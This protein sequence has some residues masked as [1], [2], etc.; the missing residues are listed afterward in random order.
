MCH[1]TTIDAM[2]R[3]ELGEENVAGVKRPIKGEWYS[4]AREYWKVGVVCCV[5]DDQGVEKNY[6]G[7]LGGLNHINGIDLLDSKKH[8]EKLIANYHIGT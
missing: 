4:K 3:T 7:V 5:S 6:N 2:W 1:Y 8:I